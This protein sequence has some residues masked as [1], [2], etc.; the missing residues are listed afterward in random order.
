MTLSELLSCICQSSSEDWQII[1]CGAEQGPS[2]HIDRQPFLPEDDGSTYVAVY[3]PDIAITLT[4]GLIINPT[5]REPWLVNKFPLVSTKSSHGC[6]CIADIFYN[7]S[8]VYRQTYVTVKFNGVAL[9]VPH[10]NQITQTDYEIV[11]LINGFEDIPLKHYEQ[12]LRIA[13]FSSH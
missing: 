2:Y 3:K 10:Q 5:L 8:L 13:G 9:P 6:S 1:I 12:T 4:Y 7:H 11:R